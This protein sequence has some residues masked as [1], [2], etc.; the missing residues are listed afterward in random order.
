MEALLPEAS[1]SKGQFNGK[2][3]VNSQSQQYFAYLLTD[4]GEIWY[5]SFAQNPADCLS[6]SF[7][8][9]GAVKGTVYLRIR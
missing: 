7:I 9:I 8:K 4:L 5:R 3:L 1:S 6:V 2:Q